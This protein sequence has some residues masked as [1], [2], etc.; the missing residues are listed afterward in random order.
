MAVQAVAIAL[1]KVP[2]KTY[3]L[4]IYGAA[5][6]AVLLGDFFIQ[7]SV[8]LLSRTGTESGALH[9]I[10]LVSTIGIL[11]AN[12]ALPRRPNVFNDGKP[13]DAEK[14]TSALGRY[15]F[16][17]LCTSYVLLLTSLSFAWCVPL[18]TLA[19]KKGTLDLDD[20]PQPGHNTR[21][22]DVT[23]TWLETQ[24][25]G[26]LWLK[27]VRAHKWAFLLQWALTIMLASG[28]SLAVAGP[29]VAN[30]W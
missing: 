11:F 5:A 28:M 1:S 19:R 27:V 13:V 23:Q 20:L 4:G 12:L 10:Q 25:A 8:L 30:I 22:K 26:R 15:R 21:A 3:Q 29:P 14:T 7:Y 9:V 16:G 17:L 6:A 2:P 24:R 18:L